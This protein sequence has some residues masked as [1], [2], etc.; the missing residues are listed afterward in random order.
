M[1]TAAVLQLI[2]SLVLI[3]VGL[4]LPAWSPVGMAFGVRLPAERVA[5]PIVQAWRRTYRIGVLAFGCVVMVVSVVATV[6]GLATLAVLASA[7]LAMSYFLLYYLAHRAVL[8]ARHREDWYADAHPSVTADTSLRTDPERYPW[9]WLLPS[10]LVIV[11]TAGYGATSYRDLPERLVLHYDANGEADRF[12]D[13][14]VW[15]AFA[16]VLAQV[17]LTVVIALLAALPQRAPAALDPA[18]PQRAAAVQRSFGA[19]LSRALLFLT[20]AANLGLF[21]IA[22]QLWRQNGTADVAAVVATLAT[23]V[24]VLAVVGTAAYVGGSARREPPAGGGDPT[25]MRDDEAHWRGGLLYVNREDPALLVPKRFGVGWTL[26]FGRPVAWVVLAVIV[27]I[28]VLT[29]VLTTLG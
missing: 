22:Q 24:G 12:I 21:F 8:A 2:V 26:N 28:P 18:D 6:E 17:C 20:A 27:A 23:T 25:R 11:I 16:P 15:S 5:A 1:I 13:T 10:L 29:T 19:A 3:V 9:S 4:V 7:A 14:A